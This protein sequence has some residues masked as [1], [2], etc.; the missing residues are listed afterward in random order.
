MLRSFRIVF[1][2]IGSLLTTVVSS[3]QSLQP[4]LKAIKNNDKTQVS[5]LLNDGA[6]ISIVDEDGDNVLMYAAL[7][8]SADCMD[9]LLKKGADP[10]A[11]NKLGETPLMWCSHDLTRS[12]LLLDHKADIN[13][14][15][16]AGNTA[17]L[18]ACTGDGQR[19]MIN[20]LL[21]K[22]ADPLAKND[23]GETTLMR[24]AL[25]GDTAVARI[26]L[27][28]GIA[29]NVKNTDAETALAMATKTV[30]KEMVYWLLDNGADAN[31]LDSYKATP[32][33]YAVVVNNIDMVNAL[34]QR[35]K[36]M[37]TPDIDGMT[38]LMWATYNEHDNPAIIQALLD[39]G[40]LVNLK[41]KNGATALSWALKKGNTATVAL[42]KKAGAQ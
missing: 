13:A 35:T 17:L 34:L 9:L 14:T 36:E 26:L 7:Y 22:G 37:N 6:G 25:F 42:L 1:I 39:R 19:E 18:I 12:K 28:R 33:A 10:N 11:R 41:D 4:L 20:L 40:A 15:T 31:I 23:K 8:A 3:S 16:N 38:F 24:V 5:S 30:N 32:L 29:I 21:E 2:S 27:N